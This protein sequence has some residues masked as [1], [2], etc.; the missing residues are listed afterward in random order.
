MFITDLNSSADYHPYYQTTNHAPSYINHTDTGSLYV[1]NDIEIGGILYTN[2]VQ[3]DWASVVA[4][5]TITDGHIFLVQTSAAALTVTLP[6]LE[7]GREIVIKDKSGNANTYNISI[8][9]PGAERID[10]S[11]SD[12]TINT[13][14]GSMTLVCDSSNWYILG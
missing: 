3:R 13:D 6:G 2:S 12:A 9:T 5:T 1:E 4:N 7:S 8:A 10:G 11:A 14:Y